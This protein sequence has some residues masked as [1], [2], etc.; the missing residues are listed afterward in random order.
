MEFQKNVNLL[1]RAFA[2]DW[3]KLV[4][5]KWIEVHDQSEENYSVN[6]KK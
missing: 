5:T 6:D 2:N 3:P 4:S 1:D